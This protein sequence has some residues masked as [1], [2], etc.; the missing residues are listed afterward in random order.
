V[1][2]TTTS[3]VSGYF[4]LPDTTYYS[5]GNLFRIRVVFERVGY[6][7]SQGI[8]VGSSVSDPIF[9]AVAGG[10]FTTPTGA[11]LNVGTLRVNS[12]GDATSNEGN[13]ATAW[14]ATTKSFLAF[15]IEGETRQRKEFGSANSYDPM[16]FHYYANLGNGTSCPSTTFFMP[17]SSRTI[18]MHAPAGALLLGRTVG[19]DG[20]YPRFPRFVA[21]PKPTGSSSEAVALG[22]SLH[23]LA[24]ML[25]RFDP[26]TAARADVVSSTGIAC[27]T[28]FH[29]GADQ[30]PNSNSAAWAKNNALAIWDLL[31]ADTTG[32]DDG[33]ADDYDIS[34]LAFMTAVYNNSVASGSSGLNH[35][36]EELTA[37]DSGTPC[38]SNEACANNESCM[39][40][41]FTCNSGDTSGGNIGDVAYHLQLLQNTWGWSGSITNTLKSSPC[42]RGNPD[43][44]H[45]FTGS[46][47]DD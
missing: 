15:E 31:D 2:A 35:F 19:C 13:I 46:Y 38:A 20:G 33:V 9:M 10:S 12:P 11:F 7:T 27:F 42:F 41:F 22:Y 24:R 17:S 45:P 43:I 21:T 30:F 29:L 44:S 28:E 47:R 37:F 34:L 8:S 3:G 26:Q 40:Q 18:D 36:F 4:Q 39:G 1:W 32:A 16:R 25:S 14:D 6:P 23:D 5:A